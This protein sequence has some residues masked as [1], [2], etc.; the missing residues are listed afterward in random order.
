LGWDRHGLLVVDAELETSRAPF[1]EVERLLCLQGG[2][3]CVAVAGNDVTT[4]KES[5]GHVFSVAGVA[6]YHLV[7][8]LE[9]SSENIS[10]LF[11]RGDYGKMY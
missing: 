7:V 11:E 2:D 6:D 10:I 9:A 4:I 3:S 1:D 8:G 5:D